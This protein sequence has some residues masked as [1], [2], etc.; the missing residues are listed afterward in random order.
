MDDII[1]NKLVHINDVENAADFGIGKIKG[2]LFSNDF[3]GHDANNPITLFID[4]V[5]NVDVIST[6]KLFR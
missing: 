6:F 1:L 5:L 4:L 3:K 2:G